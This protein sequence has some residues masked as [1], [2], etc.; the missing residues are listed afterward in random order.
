VEDDY[1]G[2]FE[3]HTVGG[4]QYQEFWIPT[5]GVSSPLCKRKMI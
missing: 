1:I 3:K 4:S 5:E 2:Q